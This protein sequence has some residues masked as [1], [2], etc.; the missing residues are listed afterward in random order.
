[1]ARVL[2]LGAGFGGIA[3]ATRL[4]SL[5]DPAHEVVLV[6]RRTDFVMGLRKTWAIVGSHPL[7]RWHGAASRRSASGASTSARPR[8]RRSIPP[9]VARAWTASGSTPTRSSSRSASS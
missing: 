4:R 7:E 2:V 6:D 5:L 8:S 9:A 1:M 3:A